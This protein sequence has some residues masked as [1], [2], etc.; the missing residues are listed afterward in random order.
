M[1]AD[2]NQCVL[3]DG[4]GPDAKLIGVEYLVSNAVYQNMPAEEKAYWHDHK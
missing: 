2:L 3:Y 4:T 1:A